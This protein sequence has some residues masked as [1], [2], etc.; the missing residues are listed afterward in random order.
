MFI[1]ASLPFKPVNKRIITLYGNVIRAA[2][3]SINADFSSY[4]PDMITAFL[5]ENR[6]IAPKQL[7]DLFEKTAFGVYECSKE[8]YTEAYKEYKHC[9]KYVRKASNVYNSKL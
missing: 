8:E 7:I 5:L 1:R 2:G 6:G 9:F 4:T 3:K